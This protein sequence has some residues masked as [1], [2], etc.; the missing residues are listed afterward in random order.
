MW[1]SLPHT[2]AVVL[3]TVRLLAK[4]VTALQAHTAAI[5]TKLMSLWGL[6]KTT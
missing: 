4:L 3:R 5:F 6:T 1:V 2:Q